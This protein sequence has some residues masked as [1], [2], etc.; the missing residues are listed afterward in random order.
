[1]GGSEMARQFRKWCVR[2]KAA[3]VRMCTLADS[4]T[5]NAQPRRELET[6][7]AE[8]RLY[9]AA[10]TANVLDCA[11]AECAAAGIDA[12]FTKPLRDDAIATLWEG[13]QARNASTE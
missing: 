10:L 5:I 13:A 11:A 7:P 9:I 1:M 12:F 8:Q 2:A 4:T 3:H 6:H